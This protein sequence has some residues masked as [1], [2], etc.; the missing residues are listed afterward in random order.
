MDTEA[1]SYA[2]LTEALEKAT[3]VPLKTLTDEGSTCILQDLID[4]K[5][6]VQETERVLNKISE[7]CP[8]KC[9]SKKYPKELYR[10]FVQKGRFPL[11]FVVKFTAFDL[12]SGDPIPNGEFAPW[13]R[14][15]G[16]SSVTDGV[17]TFKERMSK[18]KWEAHFS[19]RET[20]YK[21]RM[22]HSIQ[23]FPQA[24]PFID[25]L[26]KSIKKCGEK[27]WMANGE[28]DE[29]LIRKAMECKEKSWRILF[30][31][32]YWLT[33]VFSCKSESYR[34]FSK[35]VLMIMQII[36]LCYDWEPGME[37][38]WHDSTE[39]DTGKAICIFKLIMRSA[40]DKELPT[41]RKEWKRDWHKYLIEMQLHDVQSAKEGKILPSE[42]LPKWTT[43][44]VL[45]RVRRPPPGLEP[46][47]SNP[48][49]RSTVVMKT[50][51]GVPIYDSEAS[52]Q[53]HASCTKHVLN[54]R[55]VGTFTDGTPLEYANQLLNS[56]ENDADALKNGTLTSNSNNDQSTPVRSDDAT[57]E[58]PEKVCKMTYEQIS[59]ALSEE[60][61]NYAEG[62]GDLYGDIMA[63]ENTFFFS[64]GSPFVDAINSIC[65]IYQHCN[66]EERAAFLSKCI[67]KIDGNT[68]GRE[69]NVF[70]GA[71]ASSARKS[72][73]YKVHQSI[74]RLKK[75]TDQTQKLKRGTVPHEECMMA[76]AQLA[77]DHKELLRESE[78][79]DFAV[80]PELLDEIET[81][82]CRADELLDNLASSSQKRTTIF[83]TAK[84][85]GGPVVQDLR[86]AIV[87]T[88]E[89]LIQNILKKR[90]KRA[91][92]KR[93]T[94][95]AKQSAHDLKIEEKERRERIK[96]YEQAPNLLSDTNGLKNFVLLNKENKRQSKDHKLYPI[97][98]K[99]KDVEKMRA[100]AAS[101]DDA[102]MN[103]AFELSLADM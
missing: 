15:A 93:Q 69:I 63:E 88:D 5:E 102:Q 100:K 74:T 20:M 59:A 98:V 79:H 53:I 48:A 12:W 96:L 49:G 91:E 87:N 61:Y 68:R 72:I 94:E 57:K 35:L 19:F 81:L 24:S 13:N 17:V 33:S 75:S 101:F 70:E 2:S 62:I 67:S 78:K 7:F 9:S 8:A 34:D 92:M 76:R 47:V 66:A 39:T 80:E 29:N 44:P 32:E 90:E 86:E 18:G 37:V 40:I 28:Y 21:E 46:P 23:G 71:S 65:S 82:L 4:D 30:A 42:N 51:G 77:K 83:P 52:V 41:F 56:I 58:K 43:F 3:K 73:E 54:A 25:E 11:A 95:A 10:F 26:A 55:K 31:T 1:D 84:K 36:E 38:W 50:E 103:L 89:E 6:R 45:M 16:V 64:T 60:I 22:V 85:T 14:E 27:F 97:V 99:A